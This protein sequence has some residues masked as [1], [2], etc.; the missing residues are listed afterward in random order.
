MAKHKQILMHSQEGH[1]ETNT[2]KHRRDKYRQTDTHAHR[3]G[4]NTHIHTE[5]AKMHTNTE[6]ERGTPKPAERYGER[7]ERESR[8]RE[9]KKSNKNAVTEKRKQ[10][11]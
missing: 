8:L 11:E 5:G 10:K 4:K 3:R 6:K 9:R 7:E 1:R 2:H